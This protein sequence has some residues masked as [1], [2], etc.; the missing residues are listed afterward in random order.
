MCKYHHHTIEDRYIS[1]I[2]WTLQDKVSPQLMKL[3]F[4]FVDLVEGLNGSSLCY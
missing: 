1:A 3:H 2:S 4:Y